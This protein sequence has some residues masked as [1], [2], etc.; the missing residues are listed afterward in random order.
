MGKPIVFVSINYR[1]NDLGFS[2]SRE[3]KEAGLLN[4]GFEDQRN[5]LKWI[6]KYISHVSTKSSLA[7][8]MNVCLH[9]AVWGGGPQKVTIMGE[10][11]G[12]WSVSGHLVANNGDNEGLFRGAVGI[13][14]GPVKVDGPERQQGTFDQWV[15]KKTTLLDTAALHLLGP[16]GRTASS[17]RRA[18]TSSLPRAKLPLCPS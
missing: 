4:L 15:G 2:A 11:A 10:S 6:Q 12:S 13:S 9:R 7:K 1:L 8:C 18:L 16:C 3:M 17:L 5:G 14:G